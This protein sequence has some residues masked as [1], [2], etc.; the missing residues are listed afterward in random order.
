MW[1]SIAQSV[2]KILC[3]QLRIRWRSAWVPLPTPL[4]GHPC[5]TSDVIEQ[6]NC[7]FRP[8]KEAQKGGP[9]RVLR[10]A[11]GPGLAGHPAN[12]L[13]NKL[14]ILLIV[15]HYYL[16]ISLIPLIY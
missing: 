10:H 1:G 13:I 11:R 14:W 15:I 16:Q 5:S 9:F 7:Q 3:C 8:K 2:R 12:D 4:G 6:K